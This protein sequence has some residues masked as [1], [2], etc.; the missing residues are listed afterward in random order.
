MAQILALVF[1]YISPAKFS[2]TDGNFEEMKLLL[3]KTVIIIV[4]WNEYIERVKKV[5]IY[6]ML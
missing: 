1:M 4:G 6:K 3:T 2:Y 5:E